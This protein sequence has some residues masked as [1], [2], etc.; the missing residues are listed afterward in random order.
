ME[1]T[2]LSEVVAEWVTSSKCTGWDARHYAGTCSYTLPLLF[3]PVYQQTQALP[4]LTPT[5]HQALPCEVNQLL[6]QLSLPPFTFRI[7]YRNS[8]ASWNLSSITHCTI[9]H[10]DHQISPIGLFCQSCLK[11]GF[12]NHHQCLDNIQGLGTYQSGYIQSL[13]LHPQ[14]VETSE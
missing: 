8:V 12:Q 13:R 9:C 4:L 10:V 3:L 14:Q 2:A 5:V 11:T 7:M 1:S 6:Q